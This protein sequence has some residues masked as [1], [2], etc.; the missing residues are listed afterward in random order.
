MFLHRREIPVVV[1]Q[2]VATLDAESA[3]DDVGGV[4]NRNAQLSQFAIVAGCTRSKIAIQQW[5]EG[6]P[7]QSALNARG[8]G[9]IPGALKNFQQNKIA[10]EKRFPTGGGFQLGGRRGSMAA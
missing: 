10:D 8:M 9:V 4:P 7:A 6:V 1:Q 2:Q 5:H 3:D